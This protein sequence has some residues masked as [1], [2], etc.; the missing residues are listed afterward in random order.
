MRQVSVHC[1]ERGRLL[2]R[3]HGSLSEIFEGVVSQMGVAIDACSERVARERERV[4]KQQAQINELARHTTGEINRLWQ[5]VAGIA[6]GGGP[7]NSRRRGAHTATLPAGNAIS[8]AGALAAG[9]AAGAAGRQMVH[10]QM[11]GAPLSLPRSKKQRRPAL[12]AAP[13]PPPPSCHSR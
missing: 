6:P 3:I 12:I 9:A 13:P 7:Y 11:A 5:V 4:A 1:V 8:A 2:E 10:Q